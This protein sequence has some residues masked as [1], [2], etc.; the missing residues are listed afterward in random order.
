MLRRFLS[1]IIA[2]VLVLNSFIVIFPSEPAEAKASRPASPGAA[3]M[4]NSP[5]LPP[6]GST[7]GITAAPYKNVSGSTWTNDLALGWADARSNYQTGFISASG[8]SYA[9]GASAQATQWLDINVT[10]PSRVTVVASIIYT[11]GTQKFGIGASS[12]GG[13]DK[14]W[15]VGSSYNRESVDAVFGW[16]DIG[17]AAVDLALTLA[18]GVGE[19]AGLSEASKVMKVA[20][21]LGKL[22]DANAIIY[23]FDTLRSA[24]KAQ[25]TNIVF[26]FDASSTTAVG[27]GLRV[28]TSGCVL[29]ACDSTVLGY[30]DSVR[31]YVETANA[32]GF[33][34]ANTWSGSGDIPDDTGSGNSGQVH[35]GVAATVSGRNGKG[36][37]FDGANDWTGLNFDNNERAAMAIKGTL[38]LLGKTGAENKCSLD[39]RRLGEQRQ[40]LGVLRSVLT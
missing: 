7:S 3:R 1:L 10:E 36:L 4:L 25:K 37:K 33:W 20:D 32:N 8:F 30:V 27:V 21:Y 18:P 23:G 29:G 13:V 22:N 15:Y 19:L 26:S 24:G 16:D 39:I 9:G 12:W 35:N 11:G 14:V 28:D 17:T 38:E 6:A 34:S 5:S 31:V 40:R 2:V